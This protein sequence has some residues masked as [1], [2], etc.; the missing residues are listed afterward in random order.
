MTITFNFIDCE[1]DK[2]GIYQ[3][4]ISL[5]NNWYST[6]GTKYHVEIL[7]TDESLLNE[8]PK[9]ISYEKYDKTIQSDIRFKR[10]SYI[11]SNYGILPKKSGKLDYHKSKKSFDVLVNFNQRPDSFYFNSHFSITA[12]HDSPRQWSFNTLIQ[13]TLGYAAQFDSECYR[14]AKNDNFIL[15]DSHNSCDTFRKAYKIPESSAIYMPFSPLN[16][17]TQ[18]SFNKSIIDK[19]N[20]SEPYIFYPSTSHP[21]KNHINL[22]RA[23]DKINNKEK[24]ISLVLSGPKDKF[25]KNIQKHI[26]ENKSN[27][28]HIGYIEQNDLPSLYYFSQALVMP[29][30][31]DFMNLPSLEALACGCPVILSN[32]DSIQ[33]HFLDTVLYVD[34]KD[35]IS[36]KQQ[37][38]KVIDLSFDRAAFEKK[39]KAF[40]SKN[41][42]PSAQSDILES[43]IKDGLN[44]LKYEK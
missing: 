1:K 43:L 16:I 27:V 38:E 25:Y 17:F 35:V 41:H 31:F 30:L 2:G 10:L 22:I 6:Y 13:H 32:F 24:K 14:V 44:D 36:I 3:Y 21:I 5:F 37:V 39:S 18:G 23:I 15:L 34:P 4:A 11:F 29:S 19:Y 8:V 42:S 12:I 26:S 7:L 20:L 40:V 28:K 9:N 33:K